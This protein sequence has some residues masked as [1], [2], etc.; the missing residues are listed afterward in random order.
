MRPAKAAPTPAGLTEPR[1]V[2]APPVAF[3]SAASSLNV[4]RSS[5]S[6]FEL[7]TPFS[8]WSESASTSHIMAARSIIC[9]LTSLAASTAA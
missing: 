4:I 5:E 8:I 9:C 7:M 2:M 3:V 6:V 1:P